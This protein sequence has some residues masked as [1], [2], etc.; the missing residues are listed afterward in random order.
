MFPY[1]IRKLAYGG[2]LK[3]KTSKWDSRRTDVNEPTT[4]KI[5]DETSNEVKRVPNQNHGSISIKVEEGD[6]YLG[7]FAH[8]G[9][10][11]KG[12]DQLELG[13]SLFSNNDGV[14][15]HSLG[16][17]LQRS[18]LLDLIDL[19]E[20]FYLDQSN[21]LSTK[22]GDCFTK[23]SRPTNGAVS[24]HEKSCHDS[25]GSSF[26]QFKTTFREARFGAI[27]TRTIPPRVDRGEYVQLLYSC[28]FYLLE[29]SI[30]KCSQGDELC[31]DDEK[32]NS[33]GVLPRARDAIFAVYA[34]YVLHETNVLP[35]A[36]PPRSYSNNKLS[37]NIDKGILK[38]AWSM[39][40]IGTMEDPL[41]RR[42]F[43]SPVRIDR[44]NYLLLLQLRD[45]CNVRVFQC[46]IDKMEA[47]SNLNND[48]CKCQCGPPRDAANIIDKMIYSDSFFDLCEYHGPSSLEGLSGNPNFYKAHFKQNN[49]TSKQKKTALKASKSNFFE[50]AMPVAMID[51]DLIAIEQSD[52]IAASLDLTNLKSALDSHSSNLRSVSIQLRMSRQPGGDLQPKQRELV[53]N[54]LCGVMQSS[55]DY[56]KMMNIFDLAN[57]S[58]KSKKTIVESKINAIDS[59]CGPSE[60]RITD[61]ALVSPFVFPESFSPTLCDNIQGA[62]S[63]FH[64]VVGSAR[65]SLVREIRAKERKEQI[66]RD[67]NIHSDLAFFDNASDASIADS[68]FQ[69]SSNRRASISNKS[70]A[71]RQVTKELRVFDGFLEGELADHAQDNS[72][73]LE[74]DVSV[75]T[76]AGKNALLSLLAMAGEKIPPGRKVK[77]KRKS[78]SDSL[79]NSVMAEQSMD[80]IQ[81]DDESESSHEDDI[82]SSDNEIM[83]FQAFVSATKDDASTVD[84]NSTIVSGIGKRALQS[85]LAQ[86]TH[87]PD[88]NRTICRN[89]R[90]QR[91][92]NSMN[93]KDEVLDEDT[94]ASG[95]GK[96]ALQNLLLQA[97]GQA[98]TNNIGVKNARTIPAKK[99]ATTTR[100]PQQKA[101]AANYDLKDSHFE[102]NRTQATFSEEPMRKTRST[103]NKKQRTE[104]SALKESDRNLEADAG[105][106]QFLEEL[107]PSA[108]TGAMSCDDFSVATEDIGKKALN[109]LLA[110]VKKP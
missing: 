104:K 54:T 18:I 97:T 12:T 100:Q 8:V 39:L 15:P 72:L 110:S 98:S 81:S 29:E 75:A 58:V 107:D 41:C 27:H 78:R 9:I 33:G 83:G 43:R 51:T 49:T 57:D 4:R 53:E 94:I 47:S 65:T 2:S 63:S 50:S 80:L 19:R 59:P 74:D 89:Q 6:H 40:P 26:R 34:L 38:E 92:E 85:L 69:N 91:T 23:K 30:G 14:D 64:D 68:K 36:V 55:A 96:K 22:A 67:L 17:N 76:G 44:D 28:C 52:Q 1:K 95:I 16:G 56:T 37:G 20:R 88:V 82:F 103:I 90:K 21:F 7:D 11:P 99:R 31:W 42:S 109:A 13:D 10:K 93:G 60:A 108:A 105:D 48:F 84:D 45:L 32:D 25:L 62:L 87:E 77:G 66:Q 61:S 71:S 101:N 70:F 102:A 106:G 79:K 46:G 35:E 5:K 3:L 73:E 24:S 86:A